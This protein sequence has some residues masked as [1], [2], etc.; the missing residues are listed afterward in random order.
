MKS[1]NWIKGH[2]KSIMIGVVVVIG[3]LVA[4]HYAC[5]LPVKSEVE[6]DESVS[7]GVVAMFAGGVSLAKYYGPSCDIGNV[8]YRATCIGNRNS[9]NR[10]CDT[11]CSRSGSTCN[12]FFVS[13]A[14]ANEGECLSDLHLCN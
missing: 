2:K 11:F 3:I 7:T 6:A 1:W 5:P 8:F 9:C 12:T 14:G 10:D 13:Q 4:S